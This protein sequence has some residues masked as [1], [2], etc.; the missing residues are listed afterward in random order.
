MVQNLPIRNKPKCLDQRILASSRLFEIEQL[1]LQFS[2][3]EH[4]L[5]ERIRARGHGAVLI[6]P[7]LNDGQLL[8]VREYCAGTDNYQ[9]GFP[10]GLREAG[11]SVFEAAN[12]ELQEEVG[13]GAKALEHLKTIALAPGYFSATMDV[14]LATKLYPQKLIGDEPEELEVVKWPLDQIQQLI[15]REDFTEARSL[16]ALSL[17]EQSLKKGGS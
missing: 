8:L 3:G 5:Y 6:L 17:L 9:L 16:A 13:M 14:I 10:K 2:N 7:V 12:R 15:A 4:R 11:E 1:S